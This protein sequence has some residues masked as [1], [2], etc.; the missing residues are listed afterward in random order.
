MSV[1]KSV[2]FT[3]KPDAVEAVESAIATFLAAIGRKELGRTLLSKSY[4]QKDNPLAYL[5]VMTF[6]DEMAEEAHKEAPHT[7]AFV[8]VLYPL[9]TEAPDFKDLEELS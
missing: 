3:I 5:H 2:T 4:R 9:C 8:E 7:K 6:R 1:S